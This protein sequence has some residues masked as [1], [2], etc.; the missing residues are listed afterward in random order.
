MLRPEI[1]ALEFPD[2]MAMIL[3]CREADAEAYRRC[4]L[5]HA[6]LAEHIK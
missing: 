3:A 5:K 6:A 4:E 2:Q 1:V